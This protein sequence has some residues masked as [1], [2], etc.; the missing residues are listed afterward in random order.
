MILEKVQCTVRLNEAGS[1]GLTEVVKAGP[2]AMTIP[3]LVLVNAMNSADGETC[4]NDVIVVGEVE[5][6]Y[7]AEMERLSGKYKA[8]IAATMF[9]HS[10]AM[11]KTLYD[12][13]LPV[14]ALGK[15]PQKEVTDTPAPART[16]KPKEVSEEKLAIRTALVEAGVEIPAG[17]LS[18]DKLTALAEEKGVLLEA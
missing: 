10:H 2:D 15:S 5:T 8:G 18:L 17:N 13:D 3:E 14:T 6:T 11:P 12:A 1:V 9:P 4:V 7:G 16:K